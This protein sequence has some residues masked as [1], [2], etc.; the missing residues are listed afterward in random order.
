MSKNK[1][2][3][4]EPIF[5]TNNLEAQE[6]IH[7]VVFEKKNDSSID[8]AYNLEEQIVLFSNNVLGL[9][10]QSVALPKNFTNQPK[11]EAQVLHW[12]R[13]KIHNRHSSAYVLALKYGEKLKV[14][15]PENSKY[16]LSNL[17]NDI[18]RNFSVVNSK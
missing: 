10:V 1:T 9:K 14:Q 2:Q 15:L 18:Y 8:L 17:D 16:T 13:N 3:D 4:L 5:T 12:L 7:N 11:T 6:Y